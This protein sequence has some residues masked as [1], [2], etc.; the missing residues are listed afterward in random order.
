MTP[1]P[2]TAFA[3]DVEGLADRPHEIGTRLAELLAQDGWLAPEHREADPDTYRQHL[4][5]VSPDRRL[6]IVALVW[7]P[8]QTTPI[9][10]HVSWCIVGVYEGREREIRYRAV[11]DGGRRHLEAVG[12]VD[13]LPGHVEVIIPS[14]EADIHAV[15]AVGDTPTI[16]IHVYGADIE[17]RG[18]SIYR[19]FDDWPVREPA[20]PLAA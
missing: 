18:T 12:S 8:G 9:H 11:E 6:S 16:S 15:T 10:D 19:R 2:L 1:N 13:A 7:L 20:L 3:A 5:H 4:L 14:S 17:A